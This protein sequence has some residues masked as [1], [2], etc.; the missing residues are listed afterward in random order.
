RRVDEDERRDTAVLAEPAGAA[1]WPPLHELVGS[2]DQAEVLGLHGASPPPALPAARAVASGRLERCEVEVGFEA[3][4]LAVAAALIGR[5]GQGLAPASDSL[6]SGFALLRRP[7]Q[8][9]P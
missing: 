9:R 8:G 6:L 2:G 1:R 4:T 5:H 3:N 7:A